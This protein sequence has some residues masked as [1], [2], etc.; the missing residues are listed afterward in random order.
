MPRALS[1]YNTT[2]RAQQGAN[3]LPGR[4]LLPKSR[5]ESMKQL[6][7]FISVKC[8]KTTVDSAVTRPEINSF[9]PAKQEAERVTGA[10]RLLLPEI[11]PLFLVT[12]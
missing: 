2:S 8:Q 4:P 12:I 11:S 9:K 3:Y 1:V 6:T 7:N 10:H 5:R